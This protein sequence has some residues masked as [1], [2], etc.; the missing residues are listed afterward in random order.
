MGL[1]TGNGADVR[2]L[3]SVDLVVV[4]AFAGAELTW[5]HGFGVDRED[6]FVSVA[7]VVAVQCMFSLALVRRGYGTL[8]RR[9]LSRGFTGVGE[10]WLSVGHL[11]LIMVTQ[12]LTSVGP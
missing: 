3:T 6:D 5:P 2:V 12:V 10:G 8:R 11:W 7:A 1:D 4:K 9:R